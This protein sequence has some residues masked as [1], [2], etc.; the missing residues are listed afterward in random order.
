MRDEEVDVIAFAGELDQL[1]SERGE[2]SV[3]AVL[4]A[5]ENRGGERLATVL[6]AE[7]EVDVQQVDAVRAGTGGGSHQRMLAGRRYRLALDP[8]QEAR[9]AQWSGAL[10]ALWNAAL[11]QR[12]TAW[13]LCSASVG[14]AEQCRDLTA[15]RREVPWLE[16]V[17]AQAAQQTLRDLDRAFG[18]FF[19]G[20]GRYPRF[21]S[22]RRGPGIRFPQG[23]EVRRVNRRWGEVRLPKLG[24]LRFRWTR[25]PG[26]QVRHAT[27][28][29]DALG[30]HVALCVELDAMPAP[31]NRGPAVGVD[32]GVCALAA[33]SGGELVLG[34]FWT[35]GERRRRRV[36]EHRLARSH[37]GSARRRRTVAQLARMRARIARRRSDELHKLSNRLASR[38]SLVALEDLNVR[39]MTR[40]AKGTIEQPGINVAAKAGLNREILERGWGELR[41][42]LEYKCGWY[43]SW[44][45]TVDAR[46]TSQ[47]CAECGTIDSRSRES[48]AR[49]RCVAC[50]HAQHA[51]IN[52]ARV[53]L[54]RALEPTAGGPPVTA[55]GGLAARRPEKREPTWQQEAA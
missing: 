23:V 12:R 22:R 49:F 40:S 44:L 36:L 11:E 30:W 5:R 19:D 35:A 13:R 47:T 32:R 48:Q 8:A 54:Q 33:T 24:W 50:G 43:G 42:Q 52:A 38:H 27:V 34:E 17:P 6:D 4:Q 7:H 1:A 45:L 20:H 46:Y 10:R 28:S 51:D 2:H 15:A 53:I 41:R 3:R 26:G 29:C 39:A 16:D 55:R 18:R 31:P 9:L 25:P 37:R 21:R 14:L